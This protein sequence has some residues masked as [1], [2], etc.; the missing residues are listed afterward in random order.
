MP[1]IE[2]RRTIAPFMNRNYGSSYKQRRATQ[3]FDT[4]HL[5]VLADRGTEPHRTVNA[6][7]Q[8]IWW[9]SRI[10]ASQQS[11]NHQIP[12]RLHLP[13]H[14]GRHRDQTARADRN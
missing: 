2:N 14:T 9:V 7:L 11:T 6:L 12:C 13:V 8:S 4:L 5:P 1:S 10:H 3:R